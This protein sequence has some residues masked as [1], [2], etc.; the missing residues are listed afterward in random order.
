MIDSSFSGLYNTV[1][2]NPNIYPGALILGEVT[3]ISA[4]FVTINAFFKSDGYIPISQFTDEE[5]NLEV[6]IGSK[7]EVVIEYLEDLYGDIKL[8][9]EKAKK[10]RAWEDL[11]KIYKTND[12][13]NGY[14]TAKVKGGFT[15]K[16]NVIKAFLPGSLVSFKSA[17]DS[18][19]VKG[20]ELKF[21]IIKLEKK[22]NNI[23]LSQKFILEEKNNKNFQNLLLKINEGD[24]ISGVVKNITDYG[25]FIDLGG[26]DGLLHI[27]DMSWKRVKHPNNIL[28]IGDDI[29]VKILKFDKDTNRV[30][31]GLK[32]LT[33]DPW[34][35]VKNKYKEGVIVS[36][37]V[38][39]ITD[40]GCFVE[41]EDGIEGLV[42]LSEMDWTNKNVNPNK[43]VKQGMKVS[44][45]ILDINIDRR[46]I[47]LGLKQC[48][49]NP[50]AIFFKIHKEGDIVS[51][52]IKSI[53]DFGLFLELSGGIDGL[54]H[55][56]DLSWDISNDNSLREYK[57]GEEI[58]AVILGI[59]VERERISLGVKQLTQ[60]P[61]ISYTSKFIKGSVV[62]CF[63]IR[64]L[65]KGFIVKLNDKLDGF[66]KANEIIYNKICKKISDQNDKSAI[67][68]RII[69]ID[70]KNRN[71]ILIVKNE[72]THNKKDNIKNET[73]YINKVQKNK[74]TL[75]DLLKKQI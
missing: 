44:V 7:V 51:G 16:I 53:T 38:T 32:Q 45:S 5:G 22:K 63:V 19:E 70:K 42:H 71:I 40:Y 59:D 12:I 23:V 24:T 14:V 15:V 67:K 66:L 55:L 41:L 10:I 1:L 13:V 54:V 36:G 8:S 46:R 62:E 69:N 3:D 26:L 74:P 60:D 39:N 57:K 35:I 64:K 47:S 75:G 49:D 43:V 27:T 28:K 65:E 56:S 31:L 73:K 68:A 58:K 9:R 20:K 4:N 61:F 6:E 29:K 72:I 25:A 33:Q 37:V 50:W 34:D 48:T 30:S 11:E 52:K 2:K 18:D 17:I 21:K